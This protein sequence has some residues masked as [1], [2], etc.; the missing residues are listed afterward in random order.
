MRISIRIA[1]N[2]DCWHPR[3]PTVYLAKCY[4]KDASGKT[5][6][7]ENEFVRQISAFDYVMLADKDSGTPM[8]SRSP[9]RVRQRMAG[10]QR[11][12]G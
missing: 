6:F 5:R 4:P 9:C 11:Q 7:D 2:H 12:G 1:S 10:G 8:A 3:F